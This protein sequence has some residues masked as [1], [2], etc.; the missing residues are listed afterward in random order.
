MKTLLL[1]IVSVIGLIATILLVIRIMTKIG[2]RRST[3]A[4]KRYCIDN[5][6]EFIDVKVFPN[7]YGLYF[8]KNNKKFY[9]SFDF[10]YDGTITWIKGTP[11]EIVMSKLKK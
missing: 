8:K 7:H 2:D 3:R 10:N 4:A 1:I 5:D 11:N 9:T 6:I